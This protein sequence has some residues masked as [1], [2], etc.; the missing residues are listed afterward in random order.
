[1]SSFIPSN[2]HHSFSSTRFRIRFNHKFISF[3]FCMNFL[4]EVFRPSLNLPLRVLSQKCVKP[5]KSKVSHLKPYLFALWHVHRPNSMILLFS[6]DIVSPNLL[7]R[8]L[9]ATP[10]ILA[11]FSF[12]KQ[13][14]KSSAYLTS[15]AKPFSCGITSVSNHK[16]ST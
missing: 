3:I 4:C 11:S 5:R 12:S 1:M 15:W 8:C 10:N 16:S 14:T 9:S 2:F 13:T 6:S 7:T